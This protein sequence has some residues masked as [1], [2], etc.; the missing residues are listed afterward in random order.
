[1]TRFDAFKKEALLQ[2]SRI[3]PIKIKKGICRGMTLYG[4]FFYNRRPESL[5]DEEILFAGLEL[6]GK[7]VL[8]AGA[9]IGIYSLYF[10]SKVQ[11]GKLV[12][13]EPN[14]LN[15]FFLCKNLHANA[16]RTPLQVNC[17]LSN[18]QGKLRFVSKRYNRATGTFK[19][20]KHEVLKQGRTLV[21]EEDIDVMTIDQAVVLYRLNRVDF[22]KIDTE[23]F[24]PYVIEGMT[25]TLQHFKPNLYFEIHGLNWKQQQS[26]LNRVLNHIGPLGYQIHR[27]N[28]G[29]PRITRTNIADHGGGGY[30]A[31]ADLRADLDK[32][33]QPW[34]CTSH[35]NGSKQQPGQ[36]LNMAL[37]RRL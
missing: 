37:T 17:G 24:E 23:G 11:S 9:H 33:L 4:D 29:L 12:L 21:F 34:T 20:D 13:F 15:F 36:A 25:A 27:L 31:F 10:A 18:S 1:M 2:C 3:V 28:A 16:F 26:D 32:A 6:E 14:P 8:E 35:A 30:V 22:V 5:S 7:T 19:P